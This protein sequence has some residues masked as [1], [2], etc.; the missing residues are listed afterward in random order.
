MGKYDELLKKL[1]TLAHEKGVASA[2][3]GRDVV[4]VFTERKLR[5]M[6]EKAVASQTGT[7]MTVVLYRDDA[8]SEKKVLPN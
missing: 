1:E 6:L 2:F 5:E 3:L 7:A 4:L 8:P